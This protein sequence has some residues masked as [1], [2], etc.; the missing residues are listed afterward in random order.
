M[1][2]AGLAAAVVSVGAGAAGLGVWRTAVTVADSLVA[3][4]CLSVPVLLSF[5][6]QRLPFLERFRS[7][8]AVVGLLVALCGLSYGFE[9]LGLQAMLPRLDGVLH[10]ATALAAILTVA[11]LVFALRRIA[12]MRPPQELEAANARLAREIHM[13]ESVERELR[14]SLGDVHDAV[15]E[16]EQFAYIT[17]HDL[18]A[19]LRSIAGFSRLLSGR[20]RDKLDA[21]GVE[22]LDFID[23]GCR[24]MQS[25]IQDLLQLSRVGRAEAKLESRP[26]GETVQRALRPLAE[27]IARSGAQ[28]EAEGLPQVLAQHELLVQLFQN[29]IGNAL[30]FHREGLAPRVRVSARQD[31]ED[32]LIEVADN[33]IG[34]PADQ[35]D[36]IFAVF[37]R[38]HAA[39]EYEGTGIGLAI[40]RKI[41]AYHGGRIWAT[42]DDSGAQFHV[43][44]PLNPQPQVHVPRRTLDPA[45]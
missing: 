25:L 8:I 11:V 28:I 19:P 43:R 22:F 26:L 45:V 24:H 33:G 2:Q 4:A 5:A 16:L 14:R 40:C 13:R 42:S 31:G 44:L 1:Q 15:Q 12:R 3:A 34:I 35:L 38:L 20:Y 10:I 23:Q 17:S 6:A 41:A 39:H 36:N 37:R 7:L 27:T 18:Q 32:W 30:K 29:L 9:L 21:D